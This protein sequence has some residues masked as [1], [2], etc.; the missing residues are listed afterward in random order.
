MKAKLRLEGNPAYEESIVAEG[1][2]AYR[3]STAQGTGEQKHVNNIS[4]L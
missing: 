2:P 3:Q 4:K 1:N